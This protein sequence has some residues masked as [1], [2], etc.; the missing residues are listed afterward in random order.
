MAFPKIQHPLTKI[1]VPSTKK[2]ISLRP[3]LVKEE[4]LLLMAKTSSLQ[5]ESIQDMLQAIKQVVQ[6]CVIDK[7]DVGK[8]PL[9]DLQYIFLKLRSISINNIVKITLTD[10]EDGKKYDFE[11]DLDNVVVNFPE[12]TDKVIKITKDISI[13]MRYPESS[14]YDDKEYLNSSDNDEILYRCIEKIYDGDS[15]IQISKDNI[16][17]LKKWIEEIPITSYETIQNFFDNLP[18]LFYEINYENSVGSKKKVTL[19]KLDDFFTLL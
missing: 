6:N 12:K 11:I 18:T 13:Q 2:T 17:E 19:R 5:N 4:K 9:F 14:L 1:Q 16:E 8:M 10:E 15:V 7:I 3:M